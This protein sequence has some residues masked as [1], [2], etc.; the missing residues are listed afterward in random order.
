MPYIKATDRNKFAIH[1]Q[2]VLGILADSNDTFYIKGEYFGYFTNRCVKRFLSDPDFQQNSFNSANFNESKKKTLMQAADSMAAM[3]NRSDP[4]N[5]A[6]DLNYVIT[7]V[8]WGYLGLAK[9]FPAAN[10]GAWAYLRGI[11]ERVHDTVATVN[12][13]SQRDMTMAFRRHLVIRGVLGDVI[14]ETYHHFKSFTSSDPV[15]DIWQDGRLVV[16]AVEEE[17]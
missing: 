14:S 7:T 8:L 2:E 13:G 9:G 3:L 10:Y 15:E 12:L 5:A 4:V 6:A 16:G 17:K 1:I 11:V